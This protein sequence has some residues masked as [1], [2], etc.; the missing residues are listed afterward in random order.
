ML[1]RIYQPA[2]N[3]MQSGQAKSN[4]WVLEYVPESA[5][6]LD[7]L[8]GW[9][10]SDDMRGQVKMQFETQEAAVDFAKREGIAYRVMKTHTR[11]QLVRAGGYGENF[12]TNR[13]TVWTH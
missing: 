13:K 11:K 1:A 8:M 6:S 9:T 12:A 3:A 2:R 4:A 10:S 7:P 5:K